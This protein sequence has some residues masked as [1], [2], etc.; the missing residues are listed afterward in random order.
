MA[1]RKSIVVINGRVQEI[2]ADDILLAGGIKYLGGDLNFDVNS[3]SDNIRFNIGT[4]QVVLAA[5][6]ADGVI[7]GPGGT[8]H[9]VLRSG[10][11]DTIDMVSG[12]A[13]LKNIPAAPTA[14]VGTN[15]TQLATT[16]FVLANA[17]ISGW[18]VNIDTVPAATTDTVATGYQL[19]VGSGFTVDGTLT[20]DGTLFVVG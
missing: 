12:S 17:A 4:T 13:T 7:A 6:G 18:P 9:L 5:N 20:L 2:A 1:D 8:A 19:V 3:S 16:A 11:S 10:G 14:S 15:T